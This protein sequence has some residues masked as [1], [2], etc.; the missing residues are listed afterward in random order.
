MGNQKPD[1]KMPLKN[2]KA[3]IQASKEIDPKKL[4]PMC[5]EEFKDF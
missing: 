2:K 1:L 5:D 4:I 3:V